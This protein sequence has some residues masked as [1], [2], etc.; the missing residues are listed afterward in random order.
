MSAAFQKSAE[1]I[2]TLVREE[3][4]LPDC[5]FE[6]SASLGSECLNMKLFDAQL[7]DMF[8]TVYLR[9]VLFASY[10]H[11]HARRMRQKHLAIFDNSACSR[12]VKFVY[13]CKMKNVAITTASM[14]LDG[15]N[16]LF[17]AIASDAIQSTISFMNDL[18]RPVLDLDRGAWGSLE[19][20]RMQEFFRIRESTT[21]LLQQVVRANSSGISLA[22]P[23]ESLDIDHIPVH[24]DAVN[25]ELQGILIAMVTSWC[26]QI[27][28]ALVH[29]DAFFNDNSQAPFEEIDYWVN[30]CDALTGIEEQL[31]ARERRHCLALIGI[32]ENKPALAVV[33]R[34]RNA[35]KALVDN[36]SEALD[37]KSQLMPL[38]SIT[39]SL[40]RLNVTD[41]I[42]KL[43]ELMELISSL[44]LGCRRYGPGLPISLFLSK[45]SKSIERCIVIYLRDDFVSS[46][47]A[48]WSRPI[49]ENL[50][51]L[52][53]SIACIERY[54]EAVSI[55][56]AR[57]HAQQVS[58]NSQNYSAASKAPL[59]PAIQENTACQGLVKFKQML[60]NLQYAF[61]LQYLF[62]R[63]SQLRDVPALQLEFDNF[64]LAAEK[65]ATIDLG[66]LFNLQ[67]NRLSQV[68]SCM[69]L[70][71]D[72]LFDACISHINSEIQA[73]ETVDRKID[74]LDLHREV[75]EQAGPAAMTM[76]EEHSLVIVQVSFAFCNK[77]N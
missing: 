64:D 18:W 74:I 60:V 62:E 13:F 58:F 10:K 68:L 54:Q 56:R 40:Q 5:V 76:L 26:D 39:V 11:V 28:A 65:L 14:I 21:D 9:S 61:K 30:R 19:F 50:H 49:S 27:D 23:D 55:C 53:Q 72:S 4:V 1:Y 3:A 12:S 63:C 35:E 73:Q 37:T 6:M 75:L 42:D 31:K 38:K 43:P 20:E 66:D 77:L 36:L 29:N 46:S 71:K 15:N 22:F 70:A 8:P 24:R 7:K 2:E 57:I 34:F 59:P 17:G 44:A 45:Y 51:R 33:K 32:V 47:A 48:F 16:L 52:V 41:L 25:L 67:S 69:R